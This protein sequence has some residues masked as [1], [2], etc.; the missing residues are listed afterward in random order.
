MNTNLTSRRNILTALGACVA[1][2]AM[3]V[4]AKR[5]P[6][7]VTQP[8]GTDLTVMLRGDERSHFLLTED[9]YFLIETEVGSYEYAAP[10]ADGSMLGTGIAARN[11]AQRTA[12]DK[13]YLTAFTPETV[14]KTL[15][16]RQQA[17]SKAPMRGPG[18]YQGSSFPKKG[19]Q[20]GLVI[21][22]EFSDVAFGDKNSSQY[23]GVDA[24]EYF[25]EMLNKE[26]FD[27][28]GGTGSARDWFIENS[29]GQFKPQFDVF[30]PVKL[31]NNVAYYG[32][33]DFYGNDKNAHMMVLEACAA[34]DETVDFSQY[35]RDGDGNVDNV[36]VFYAGYGE[37][38]GGGATTVWPHSWELSSGGIAPKDRTFDGVRVDKYA[39]SNETDRSARRPDGIG[40]FVH[41]FSHV[42]G[43]PDLYSTV[44]NSAFTPGAFSVMD[45]GLYNNNGRTPPNY[46][47]FE[48]YAF[49]WLTPEQFER[50]GDYTLENLAQSNK[51][52]II[53]TERENEYFL[54]ENR[55]NSGWDAY[56]PGSGMLVWHVD[57]NERIFTQN[58][59][60]NTPSHQYVDL[61]EADNRQTTYTQP[62]DPFPGTSKKTEFGFETTPSLKSWGG[63]STGVE[64]SAIAELEPEE[65]NKLSIIS[66][67][68]EVSNNEDPSGIDSVDAGADSDGPVTYYNLQG[69]RVETPLAGQTVIRRQGNSVRKILVR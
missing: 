51:A 10:A 16:A 19:E 56:I 20:K 55:Q 67:H 47:A 22:V 54:L 45:Y 35:D 49:D 60:N 5:E 66:M 14:A 30:G 6:F 44:E 21:L 11:A 29:Q 7:T 34:L 46:S 63:K 15:T 26:G 42:L 28:F 32:A 58:T 25:S 37:A 69:I 9:G 27:T 53:K 3:S 2:G 8:D 48:R 62:G 33:N 1:F 13:R 23:Q 12:A 59:V 38:D 52:Y 61:V 50:I 68:V 39:C 24:Y 36:Y 31:D 64:I 65:E 17:R 43:L 4:P 40:T 57:Y 18:L 41:E